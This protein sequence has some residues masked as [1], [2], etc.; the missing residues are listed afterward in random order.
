MSKHLQLAEQEGDTTPAV[1]ADVEPIYHQPSV[2]VLQTWTPAKVR[3]AISS[4][5]SGHMSSAAELVD[6]M[7]ADESIG[8]ALE[9]RTGGLQG[10]P[11]EFKDGRADDAE[12]SPLAEPL[13]EDWY[14]AYPEEETKQIAAWGLILGVGFA[15][16]VWGEFNG[17]FVP[18][19][20][21][22]HAKHFVFNMQI[23]RWQV[24]T[25]GESGG[26]GELVTI[27]K[28]DPKW[29]VYTPY[30][31]HRPWA[32]GLWRGLS[33][34]WLA[35]NY[36]I[37]DMGTHSEKSAA[38]VITANGDRSPTIEQ[39]KQLASEISTIGANGV[40][41]LPTGFDVD[42]LESKAN[43]EELYI[44]QIAAANS[45]FVLA[46]N[47]QN[48]TTEVKGG[49]LAAANVHERV[50]ARRI[51]SDGITIAGTIRNQSL[52]Y[53][54][55]WNFGRSA[56]A[57]WPTWD[58]DPPEDQKNKAEVFETT[59][60]GLDSLSK[61]GFKPDDIDEMAQ[62]LDIPKLAEV[63]REPPEGNSGG[64]GD[65]N[66][67]GGDPAAGGPAV[68]AG[69]AVARSVAGAGA[70]ASAEPVETTHA[71]LDAV[72]DLLEAHPR[73]I[74]CGGPRSGKTTVA[75]RAAERYGRT[76]RHGDALV[77]SHEW[78]EASAEVAD[79]LTA[80]GEWIIEGVV[81]ARAL[82]KW[83]A[84]HTGE[85]LDVMVVHFVD[86]V[87]VRNSGQEDMATGEATVWDEILGELELAV[88]A[89]H[90]CAAG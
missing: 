67:D 19:L 73:A 33:R 1:I 28:N 3:S 87:Q 66:P 59:A 68:G 27:E 61:A 90:V 13:E 55:E 52:V 72:V 10:L 31:S 62:E 46:I 34:W 18:R 24:R 51:R 22:W 89:V 70:V 88:S 48:L 23:D 16:Q 49:S 25:A 78:S 54:T 7:I 41:A 35:K 37:N 43:I 6:N 15:E 74:L 26:G 39:R 75:T 56:D 38:L 83:M 42:L 11:L 44:S 8:G 30:G 86:A 71:H 65:G 5:D 58:T 2:R 4:A 60:R 20:K 63:K 9:T 50:E 77:A 85:T 53:W 14:H 47:G 81:G 76:L 29:I 21:F 82:R 80:D 64:G 40:I 36:A 32:R 17:R 12:D 84:A 45:A 79:W 57:P 69:G